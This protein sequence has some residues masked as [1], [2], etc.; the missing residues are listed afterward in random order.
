M[1]FGNRIFDATMRA[2]RGSRRA[3]MP[4]AYMSQSRPYWYSTDTYLPAH[5]SE[6]IIAWVALF[7]GF[8]SLSEVIGVLA[9][10]RE[11]LPSPSGKQSAGVRIVASLIRGSNLASSKVFMASY[12]SMDKPDSLNGKIGEHQLRAQ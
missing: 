11:D 4:R 10:S 6:S 7:L 8:D 3:G 1:R 5:R 9:V 2:V 12:S